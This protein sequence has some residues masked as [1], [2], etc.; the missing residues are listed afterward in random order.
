MNEI[1]APELAAL[2]ADATIIDVREQG[3]YDQAHIAGSILIPMSAFVHRIA[4]LPKDRTLH[5]LCATGN[6]SG[7]VTAYLEQEGF[8]AVNVAGGITAWQG[9]GQ[10]I[11][12]A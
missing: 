6:R 4:E 7:R 3:E 8:D 2:G 12:R 1:S 10:P 11:E 5:V 9:A